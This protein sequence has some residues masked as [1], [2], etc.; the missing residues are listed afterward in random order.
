MQLSQVPPCIRQVS[1]ERQGNVA[2]MVNP[3]EK[4]GSQRCL[5]LALRFPATAFRFWKILRFH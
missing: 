1:S 2:C 5:L 3:G 4:C